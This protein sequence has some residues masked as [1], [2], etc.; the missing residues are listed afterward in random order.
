MR[1]IIAPAK[2]SMYFMYEMLELKK[3]LIIRFS[4]IGDIIL[5]SPL[6]RVLYKRFPASKIDFVVRKQYAELIHYHPGLNSI[7]EFDTRGGFS[8]LHKLAKII[9]YNKY[10]LI[11]DIH[12]SLRSRYIR[13]YSGA[14]K[15]VVIDKRIL[16]RTMLVRFKKKYYKDFVSVAGRYIEPL[17]AFG[18]GNDAKGLEIFIPDETVSRI[19]GKMSPLKLHTFK[20][21]VGFCPSAKHATKRWPEERFIETG[22]RLAHELK[23]KIAIFGGK[24]DAA[25]CAMI[26]Q[27]INSKSGE[28]YAVDYSDQFS[29]LE[30][31]AAIKFCDII[32][33]NDSG[34]MH[35][36]AAMGKKIV[37]I[38]GSTVREFGFFPIGTENIIV[39][40]KGLYCRPCSHIG[41]SSCPEGHFRCMNEI[42]T[43]DVVNA[44]KAIDAGVKTF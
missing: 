40:R 1:D 5:A 15:A 10:D 22:I 33:T 39:E 38:F 18:I 34:L 11:I 44:V 41:R 23:A 6:I 16:A 36:A 35:I 32:V 9:R 19:S 14:K 20:E 2:K 24:S 17:K 42:L 25:L 8:E 7:Y 30:T 28:E 27:G 12:N 37:A 43:D 3:I 13:Y 4:S 31:A 29:L 21:I 26:T